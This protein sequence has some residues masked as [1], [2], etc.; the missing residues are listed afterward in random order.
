MQLLQANKILLASCAVVIPVSFWAGIQL[1]E[2]YLASEFEKA[3]AAPGPGERARMARVA[4]LQT[5]KTQLL[6][7]R[8]SLDRKIEE[9]K[10]RNAGKI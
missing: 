6:E 9:I 5:E 1:K 3:D 4:Q 8:E 7:E 2:R 10:Q